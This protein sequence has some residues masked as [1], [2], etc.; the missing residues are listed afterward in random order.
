MMRRA[1]FVAALLM[2]AALPARAQLV[3]TDTAP[4][5]SCAGFPQGATRLTA[6]ADLNGAEVTLVCNGTNWLPVSGGSGSIDA[7]SDGISNGT[8][9]V[10][11]GVNAGGSGAG[12]F[13]AAV[14][15]DA[16]RYASSGA[17]NNTAIGHEALRS[18]TTPANNTGDYNAALGFRAMFSNTEG[19][20]NAALGTWALR[21]NISGDY[22]TALGSLALGSNT[23]GNN[24][25]ALGYQAL[26]F[27]NARSRSTA[28]GYEAMYYADGTGTASNA[29]NVA[30]GYQALYGS[31]TPA[32]NTGVNNTALGTN[33][34]LNNTAG[35]NNIAIGFQAGDLNTTGTG[36][37]IIGYDIDAPLAATSNYLNLGGKIFG[38][39]TAAGTITVGGTAALKVPAGTD[40]ERPAS[41]VGGMIRF[42]STSNN[43]EG[44]NGTS[45]GGIGGSGTPAGAD[46]Q[47]QLNSAG[48]FAA[49]AGLV[50]SPTGDLMVSGTYT[51]TASVPASGAG[52]RM[53]FDVQK[54]A[55]RAGSA[56]AAEWDNASIGN[57]STAMGSQ[58]T[59]SGNYSLAT[60]WNTTASGNA[61][62]AMG[63]TNTASDFASIAM[64]YATISS[65]VSSTAIGRQV[66]AG[67]G[68]AG[69]GFGDGSMALGLIDD[70]VVISTRSQVTGI[71]SLGIFM[72]DQ[73]GLVFASSNT[74]GLFGGRMVIDPAVPATNLVADTALEVAGSMK[75]G[76]GGEVCAAGVAGAIR[77]NA[78]TI[79][80]CNGT[81]WGGMGGSGT[82]AGADRQ[83]QLNSA[84]IFAAD[85]GLVFSSTGD[86]MVSGTYTGTASVP[87]SGAG[88]RMF[89]DV[90]KAAFRAGDVSGTQWNNAS[91]GNYS[92]AMGQSTTASGSWSTAIGFGN[93]ASG[94]TSTAMGTVTTAS[95]VSSTAIGNQATASGGF[96]V[97][98]G[99][100]NVASGVAST[101][102]GNH[103][104]AGN[105][106]AGS[107]LGDGSVAMGLID[108][109]VTIT[110]RSQVTGIQ[111]L[112][113]FM[114]DQ[115]GLVVSTNN[116]MSLLGGKMV[117]DPRVPAVN[118][119]AD[120]ALEVEGAL[121]IAYDGQSCAAASEGAIRYDSATDTF[122]LCKTAGSW[123]NMQSGGGGTPA[124]ADRE[125][126]LNSAGA[127]GSSASLTFS[128]SGDFMVSDA[129]T[130][131]ASVP[132]SGPGVRMFFE[133][134][135]A[136]FRSGQVLG[137]E[138]DNASIGLYSI[139]VG[140]SPTASG[141]S[142]VAM[143]SGAVSSAN[144]SIAM[145]NNSLSSGLASVSLGAG[146]NA[147]ATASVALGS[148]STASGIVSTALGGLT[149]AA[150]DY[151]LAA[152]KEV[153]VTATADGSFGFGLTTAA[154][155][156]DPQVSGAQSF[157]IFMGNQNAVNFASANTMGLFGGR[158]VID[159]AVP[160]TNLVA[161]ATLEV[162]GDAIIRTD[163]TI[164]NKVML[165][166][167]LTPATI[168][169]SQNDYNPANLSTASVLRLTASGAFNIT[170]LAGGAD[171]RLLV[172]INVGASNI[173][174]VDESAL[175]TAANRFALVADEVLVPD[176]AVQLLYDATS[177]RWRLV[178]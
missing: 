128:S 166:G 22:N 178:R 152:G 175:S 164:N 173:T 30:L 17:L 79:Q 162:G 59:A 58:T 130:G 120:T 101:A 6:D 5:S 117:I 8:D 70:A 113:I 112:G 143:G 156:T 61:S 115:D 19:D 64:G 16:L 57:Y 81:S 31:T 149:T 76:D 114:G 85:A 11:L 139:A 111:S 153:N 9:T 126:Q 118:L 48:A 150:G 41:A 65:G 34:M 98:M 35:S 23:T 77:Y 88:T 142:S 132:A 55:F 87:A 4:G 36:N 84:G 14:G 73:D 62:T 63:Q 43:F 82:P 89:F 110:T 72:G 93:T 53:F 95:G 71:Q 18:S 158:M 140:Q 29:N 138:W 109:A 37:I 170:G 69:S 10:F 67:N 94:L 155:A 80:F 157:G 107:G 108:D 146:T 148:S 133:L 39:I 78:G 75:I 174:L 60:G 21:D 163:L 33:A 160:A 90:Q 86:L 74:M 151:S 38:D 104:T 20:F 66:T 121:K 50:F 42:N 25:T 51:G 26:H 145:G 49:A 47:I 154:P 131:S 3:G 167:D 7:L 125:I 83:I 28:I 106:T 161:D 24:N 119:A 159:P 91:I 147:S 136:A 122:E 134:Q 56:S 172:L 15:I 135:R 12:G 168:A 102:M 52:T 68:T 97:A 13:S 2:I 105:G 137:T 169:A 116:Q 144:S 103:V 127:F 96:A 1:L 100:D 171:G 176:E 123:T 129:F 165:T 44:Y 46:R 45:W 27:N 32:N 141:P 54:A 99:F 40:A 177:Q 92:T 124:G